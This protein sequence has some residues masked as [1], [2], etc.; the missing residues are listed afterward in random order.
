[1]K[2][3][4]FLALLLLIGL[5]V[6]TA[7]VLGALN[8]IVVARDV[9]TDWIFKANQKLD[10]PNYYL[11]GQFPAQWMT[12]MSICGLAWEGDCCEY[13]YL[14][15]ADG[16]N[17]TISKVDYAHNILKSFPSPGPFPSGMTFDGTDLWVADEKESKIYKIATEDGSI[18][19]S[20]LSPI[21]SPSGIAWDG[22]SLWVVGMDN[23][24]RSQSTEV[25]PSL[26]MMN[27]DTGMVN[28]S[29]ALPKE[30]TRPGS[31]EWVNGIFWVG[32]QTTNRVFKL[33][34]RHDPPLKGE[35]IKK[36]ERIM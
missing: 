2:G 6:F 31:L 11:H 33:W 27:F 34:Q 23:P 12:E 24:K 16:T 13:G 7:L 1:M 8:Q 22:K 30:L 3:K 15:I 10:A 26:V 29:L 5:V 32:D 35:D 9:K 19:E 21:Q 28:A 20:Y 25:R 18:L 36:V 4:I 14:W 17:H